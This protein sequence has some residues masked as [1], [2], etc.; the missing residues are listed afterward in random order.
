[1]H[2]RNTNSDTRKLLQL[3]RGLCDPP[4][5]GF[6]TGSIKTL[7]EDPNAAGVSVPDVLRQLWQ[8]RY[9]AEAVTVAVVGPQETQELLQL[10]Q[11][12]FGSMQSG[13]SNGSNGSS[14]GGCGSNGGSNGVFGHVAEPQPALA[15]QQDGPVADVDMSSSSSSSSAGEESESETG[16][17]TTTAAAAAEAV[18]HAKARQG[19]SDLLLQGAG[20]DEACTQI[21]AHGHGHSHAH[22]HEQHSPMQG[23]QLQQSVHIP[24]Q[25]QQQQ[26]QQHRYPTDVLGSAAGGDGVGTC[27]LYVTVCPQ[28]DLRE[29]QVQWYIP[30]GACTHS[31]WVLIS[32]SLE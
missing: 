8:E 17:T 16:A 19:A 28:R 21:A 15:T 9:N 1:V 24:Q 27:G 25:P 18:V 3:K 13:G 26:Q 30:C 11:D 6:S 20:A 23:Q 4:Y 12:T 14:G 2:S 7:W 5:S 22:A 10:V 32:V 29:L 31:R